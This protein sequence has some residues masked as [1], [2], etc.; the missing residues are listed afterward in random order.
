MKEL[1]SSGRYPNFTKLVNLEVAKK[2]N[3]PVF[4]YSEDA[5][6]KSISEVKIKQS[7]NKTLATVSLALRLE[8]ETSKLEVP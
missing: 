6:V 1:E 5:G 2:V 4:W 7:S 8:M 3:D